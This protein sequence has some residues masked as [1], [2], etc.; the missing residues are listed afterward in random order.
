MWIE[1]IKEFYADLR[2]QKT[3]ALLTIVA[4][5]WGTVA[6]VL[7]LAFGQGL[8]RQLQLGLINAGNQ[9]MILYPG[10]TSIVYEGMPKG[11]K[12]HLDEEDVD[13]LR[14]AIPQIDLASPQYRA[15]V[16]LSYGR[17]TSTTECEGV[18]PEFDEMRRM[19]PAA[20]GRFLDV[21]DVAQQRR[22]IFLGGVIAKRVLGEGDPV[23]KT[24]NVDGLPFTVVGIMPKKIQTSENNGPDDERAII[25]YTTMRTIYGPEHVNSIL[26]RPTDPSKQEEVKRKIYEILGQKYHF[27]PAD[28]HTI[29]IW[30]F[31]E[32]AKINAQISLGITIF[33]FSVGLLTLIIAGVGVANVMYAVVKERTREIGVK[34]AVGARKSYI[35]AQVTFEALMLAFIGGAIGILFSWAVVSAVLLIP[36]DADGPMQFLG[37]PVFSMPVVGVTITILT[38]IGLLAGYFPARKAANLDPVESL[39]YE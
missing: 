30:D 20:G 14:E 17:N 19:F 7:L 4:I 15:T 27:D 35:L 24:I 10:E 29:P 25:P 36:A 37:H 21:M 26:V 31:I 2:S 8:G 16:S 18:N 23:G 34:M 33:L 22:A 1:L 12:I 5:A 11:R 32:D 38:V 9:I 6:V 3:R 13:L 28:D 39:R